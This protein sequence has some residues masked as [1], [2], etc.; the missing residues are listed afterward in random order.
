M[1]L[2]DTIRIQRCFKRISQEELAKQARVSRQTIF[3]IEKSKTEPSFTLVR[4]IAKILEFSLDS[5]T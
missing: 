4:R 3:S 5:L 1:N 2:A